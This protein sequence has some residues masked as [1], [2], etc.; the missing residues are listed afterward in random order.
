MTNQSVSN[1]QQWAP[2]I[3]TQVVCLVTACVAGV[4]LVAVTVML[5]LQSVGK[6]GRYT[7]MIFIAWIVLGVGMV[8][9]IAAWF[10]L[11]RFKLTVQEGSNSTGQHYDNDCC[12]WTPVII[13]IAVVITMVLASI[14]YSLFAISDFTNHRI[15]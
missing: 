5:I 1:S 10:Y 2:M 6:G 15:G 8:W 14:Y 4:I 7:N 13:V 11:A 12:A 3:A 9:L